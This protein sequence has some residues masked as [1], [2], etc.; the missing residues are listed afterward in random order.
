MS[1]RSNRSVITSSRSDVWVFPRVRV[2]LSTLQIPFNIQWG[3]RGVTHVRHIISTIM[4]TFPFRV[5]IQ[6]ALGEEKWVKKCVF[7]FHACNIFRYN[8]VVHRIGHGW[9]ELGARQLHWQLH[10]QLVLRAM[11]PGQA[12][13]ISVM[14]FSRW[15]LKE[16]G[17]PPTFVNIHDKVTSAK[18]L[19]HFRW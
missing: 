5:N 8:S 10:G 19:F 6:I 18:A 14:T 13:R 1:S 4:I 15:R 3:R 2:Q 11:R 17:T 16:M 12:W 9:A 7:T